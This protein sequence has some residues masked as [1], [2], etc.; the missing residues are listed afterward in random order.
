MNL[1]VTYITQH[2][3]R[4]T[5]NITLIYIDLKLSSN[6]KPALFNPGPP[7]PEDLWLPVQSVCEHGVLWQIGASLPRLDRHEGRGQSV[8]TALRRREPVR[9]QGEAPWGRSVWQPAAGFV[10]IWMR[11]LTECIS[12]FIVPRRQI[13]LKRVLPLIHV[14]NLSFRDFPVHFEATPRF[15]LQSD[16]LRERA[17]G[18]AAELLLWV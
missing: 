15:P 16:V 8:S 5:G 1:L 4:D 10:K 12:L 14:I 13:C 3:Y 7:H 2:H 11:Y 17:A 9:V 18:G 6:L